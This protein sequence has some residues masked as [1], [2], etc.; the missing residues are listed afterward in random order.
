[1]ENRYGKNV[2]VT[3]ASSGIGQACAE[4]F[5]KQGCRVIGVSR[6]CKEGIKSFSGGGSLEMRKLDVT[7]EEEVKAFAESLDQVDIA[8]L[9]AGYGIG[10]S[11]EDVPLEQVRAQFD[12]LYFSVVRL[13]SLILPKMR[14][15][16]NGLIVFIGSVAGRIS[17]PMQGHYSAAKYA[18]EAYSDALR[19]EMAPYGIRA[20][21]VEPG[22][23]NTGFTQ[24]RKVYYKEGSP[25][26]KRV[27]RAIAI[28]EKDE[29]SGYHPR[30]VAKVVM[31]LCGKDDPPAK[32]AV[33]LSY[34]LVIWMIKCFPDRVREKLIVSRY[35][36]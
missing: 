1:M 33:G 4:A 32:V 17:I 14:L 15:Q 5:A 29:K 30:K 11:L 6:H 3:G 18:L 10:G 21:T 34:K 12:V 16:K 8:V 28:M 7:H 26:N 22:D 25:H 24:H 13:C 31:K 20:V 2:L 27:K 19:I 23:T 9:S 35:M 36:K